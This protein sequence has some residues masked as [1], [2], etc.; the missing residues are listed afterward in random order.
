MTPPP[1]GC[2]CKNTDK[3][4]DE[5]RGETFAQLRGVAAM[6]G[7]L[8]AKAIAKV[9]PQSRRWPATTERMLAIAIRKVSGLTNDQRLREMLAAELVAAAARAWDKALEQAG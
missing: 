4:C 7:E 1:F 3:L 6:R 8:W 2:P 9:I 5:C